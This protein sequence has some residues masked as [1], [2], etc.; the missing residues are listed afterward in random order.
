ME[1]AN[2]AANRER[3]AGIL[4]PESYATA[5]LAK[6]T[7]LSQTNDFAGAVAAYGLYLKAHPTDSDILVMRAGAKIRLGDKTGAAA[8]YR[9]ALKYIPDYQPALD[10]LKQIGAPR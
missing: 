8:D 4:E 1:D 2:V 10:G 5:T 6:A 7:A 3:F 9:A